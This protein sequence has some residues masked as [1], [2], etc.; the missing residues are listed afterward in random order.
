LLSLFKEVALVVGLER[1]EPPTLL[2]VK[3]LLFLVCPW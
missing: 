1:A 3:D 2:V